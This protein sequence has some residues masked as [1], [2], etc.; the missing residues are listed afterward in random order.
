MDAMRCPDLAEA[1]AAGA[2]EPA[3]REAFSAH[4]RECPRCASAAARSAE[5]LARAEDLS[6]VPPPPG[7]RE[8][9]LDL[10]GAPELPLDLN[11]YSWEEPVPGVRMHVLREDPARGVR[12]CLV[13]ATPGARHPR[14]RHLG[15]ENILVLQGRLRDDRAT[16]GPGQICRSRA[17]SVHSE[18]A[19]PGDD[20]ICY[21]VYYGALEPLPPAGE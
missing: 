16:Y 17:G 20:C 21:V 8:Q 5:A 6:P 7:L 3:E 9:V 4:A 13:W 15:A 12:A 14:H 1:Y 11:A 19:L 10:A 18:E 2:L